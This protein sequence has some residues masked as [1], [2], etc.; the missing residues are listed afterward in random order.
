[1][2]NVKTEWVSSIQLTPTREREI[3]S[4]FNC[5]VEFHYLQTFECFNDLI[6]DFK[7]KAVEDTDSINDTEYD[8]D[9]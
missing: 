9:K 7:L 1:M 2:D 3:Q 4:S 6:E 5:D 8:E